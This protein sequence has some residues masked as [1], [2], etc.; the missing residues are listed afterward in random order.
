MPDDR[1]RL[2]SLHLALE[3]ALEQLTYAQLL[4]TQGSEL[5]AAPTPE[6]QSIER[7]LGEVTLLRN[8]LRER[9][10]RLL[11]KPSLNIVK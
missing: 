10:M 2:Q 7:A 6:V 4:A 11:S 1:E 8:Q 9:L 5:G 3:A